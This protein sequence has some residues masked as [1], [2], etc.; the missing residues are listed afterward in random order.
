MSISPILPVGNS[1]GLTAPSKPTG[2]AGL[3]SSLFSMFNT[4]EVSPIS[5][6][7]GVNADIMP[8]LD[9][10]TLLGE[11]TPELQEFADFIINA[12]NQ[13]NIQPQEIIVEFK[14][15][16]VE[17][18]QIETKFGNIDNLQDLASA[19][20]KLGFD[21]AQ[22]A[23][24][25]QKVS[26]IAQLLEAFKQN[27]GQSAKITD[28][29][30]TKN[31]L[32]ILQA[33]EYSNLNNKGLPIAEIRQTAIAF[34]ST[35]EI[36]PKTNFIDE[37]ASKIALPKLK[38]IKEIDLTNEILS[39]DNLL[40]TDKI[41]PIEQQQPFAKL[42]NFISKFIPDETVN[43]EEFAS[44]VAEKNKA[45]VDINLIK[46][47]EVS[48]TKPEVAQGQKIISSTVA[49][50]IA[51][52]SGV[53]IAEQVTVKTVINE[54]INQQ[55]KQATPVVR[56]AV[57]NS[58]SSKDARH[59]T[60][61]NFANHNG[62]DV[63]SIDAIAP[64]TGK[65]VLQFQTD[66]NGDLELIDNETKDKI[67]IHKDEVRFVERLER[68]LIEAKHNTNLAK[69]AEKANVGEQV[70]IQVKNL[71]SK[72]G[73]S[74]RVSLK[75]AELGQVDIHLKITDG[76]VHGTILAQN[77]EVIEQMARD[78]RNLQ[79]GLADAGLELDAK[80]IVFQI[81]DENNNSSQQQSSNNSG[82]RSS[83]E[84]EDDLEIIN[85]KSIAGW[86]DP[87]NLIDV[88]I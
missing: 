42:D 40:S 59:A 5:P 77:A 13:Q 4:T 22:A 27:T 46:P 20:E 31:T 73:G 63:R 41:F 35:I 1:T 19:Y 88:S 29:T 82:S 21:K 2:L 53:Q 61:A 51:K 62:V 58:L 44:P 28:I 34:T 87:D 26:L 56:P 72:G 8:Q 11:I 10:E 16:I 38:Q 45:K 60:S 39:T 18:Q 23:E 80:G 32:G 48:V 74:I 49:E 52:E 79:Q 69:T 30:D 55:Q 71:A 37:I 70:N 83:A 43:I 84:Y 36:S 75:P 6:V 17:V 78:L 24:K 7:K 25:V 81:G 66:E 47:T 15:V 54:V 14:A 76:K 68:G 64:V 85:D 33:N 9:A 50:S 67:N 12:T 65:D 57:E 3:F 86:T